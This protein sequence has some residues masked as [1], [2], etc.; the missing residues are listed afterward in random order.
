MRKEANERND[1]MTRQQDA[2]NGGNK[3]RKNESIG[4]E[5][6]TRNNNRRLFQVR[7]RLR[8]E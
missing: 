7:T 3:T 1:H 2:R 4:S 8:L 5:T 6:S